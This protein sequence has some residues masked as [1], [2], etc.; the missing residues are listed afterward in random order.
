M[1]ER[2]LLVVDDDKRLRELL[3]SPVATYYLLLSVTTLLTV[4]GLVMV[5]SA[6]MIVL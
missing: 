5:L 2:K 1:N 3:D 4:I 6:S